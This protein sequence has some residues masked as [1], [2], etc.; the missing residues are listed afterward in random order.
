MQS[1]STK[2]SYSREDQR[3]R[4]RYGP[5]AVVTGA[6]DGIGRAF[7]ERLAAA[8]VNLVIAARRGEQLQSL[9]ADLERRHGIQARAVAVD[10]GRPDGVLLL[11]AETGELDVGLLVAA[12]GFG[13]SGSFIESD[14]NA[15]LDMIDV[16]CR[17]VAA[18]SHAFG[19]RFA[20]QR[21]GGMVLMSSLVAFQGVPRAANYAA[22]KAYVQSLAEGL[23]AELGPHGVDVLASAPGPVR[24]GF[25]A[26]AAM[27]MSFAQTPAEVASASLAALGRRGTVR[28]GLLAKLLEWSLALLPR[29]GRVRMMAIVMGGMTKG[30]A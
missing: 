25:A 7:A 28:P 22:T 3:L 26:R 8:G 4:G 14:V 1:D 21:R 6:T 9:G 16:N 17:A 23:R 15:E 2:V 24:S 27:T 5:W 10:L 11:L 29:W 18:L 19:K 13:T 12:A 30:R 20:Q